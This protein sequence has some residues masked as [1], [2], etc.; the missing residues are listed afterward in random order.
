MPLDPAFERG[1]SLFADRPPASPAQVHPVPSLDFVPGL[2][3][4]ALQESMAAQ[5]C[6]LCIVEHDG[7]PLAFHQDLARQALDEARHARFFL[8][9][10]RELLPA[11]VEAAPEGHPDRAAAVRFLATGVG[12][13]VPLE[14]A[15]Y[16]AFWATDLLSRL[17]LLHLDDEAEAARRFETMLGA[18]LQA[19]SP[20]L[21]AELTLIQHDEERH[22]AMGGRWVE[23]LL[24][25]P[26]HRALEIARIR[27]LRAVTLLIGAA[28]SREQPVEQLLRWAAEKGAALAAGR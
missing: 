18:A 12:L 10:A 25:D 17:V 20:A 1:A 22:A 26:G 8:R 11:F 13:R 23:A 19:R 16:E 2:G 3:L 28:A 15:F 24:P 21:A 27:R 7:L 9:A 5:V 6:A 14:G 4:L